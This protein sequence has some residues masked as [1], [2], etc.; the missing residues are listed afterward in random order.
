[1]LKFTL[2]FKVLSPGHR[3]PPTCMVPL[4]TFCYCITSLRSTRPTRL[5]IRYF[6]YGFAWSL[7]IFLP[8]S[9]TYTCLNNSATSLIC[10]YQ[11]LGFITNPNKYKSE[12][13]HGI[14]IAGVTCLRVQIY[15]AGLYIYIY[16]YIQISQCLWI[17]IN[18]G[19]ALVTD[20]H[21]IEISSS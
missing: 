15:Q 10:M 16:I 12:G 14:S 8:D 21:L 9:I 7:E 19:V 2:L 3:L 11:I 5:E 6:H 1:M 20:Y 13:W 17:S 18:L 4:L